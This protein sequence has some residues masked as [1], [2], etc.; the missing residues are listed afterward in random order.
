MGWKEIIEKRMKARRQIL[1]S[2][3]DDAIM[4]LNLLIDGM[5]RRAVV[6]WALELAEETVILLE[7]KY[8]LEERPRTALNMTRMWASGEVKMSVAKHAI[9]D[10]HAVAKEISSAVDIA[11][12]HAIGQ[13]C[14]TVHTTGHAIGFPIYDLTALIRENGL[15]NC[16]EIICN[17]INYYIGKLFYWK[18]NYMNCSN[19][20]ASFLIDKGR[21]E[22]A[23]QRGRLMTML[24][25]D[26][27]RIKGM[28]L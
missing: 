4:S 18:E 2:K 15:E 14:G 23:Q 8:P 17:R 3:D 19:Q 25:D 9:L 20:W 26:W 11:R 1:F 6:L 24:E 27:R 28:V 22:R 5:P 21:T 7:A 12:C 13:A 16:D 10:C